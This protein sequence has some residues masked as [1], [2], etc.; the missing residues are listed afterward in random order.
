MNGRREMPRFLGDDRAS[1]IRFLLESLRLQRSGLSKRLEDIDARQAE[2]KKEL[3]EIKT[4]SEAF[5]IPLR[6]LGVD[7][8]KS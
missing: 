3:E 6:F 5:G 1:E 4:K 7:D 8:A 2:Y